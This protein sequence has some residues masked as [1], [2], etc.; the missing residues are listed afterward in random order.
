M[1]KKGKCVGKEV[2]RFISCLLP[3]VSSIH[4]QDYRVNPGN[5]LL[6]DDRKHHEICTCQRIRGEIFKREDLQS[7]LAAEK[8]YSMD[9]RQESRFHGKMLMEFAWQ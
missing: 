9:L 3:V 6:Q 7:V 8:N 1:K 4:P 5:V 2:G